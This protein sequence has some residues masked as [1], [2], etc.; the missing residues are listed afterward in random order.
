MRE[1]KN[2]LR[3]RWLCG[4]DHPSHSLLVHSFYCN[5]IRR[6]YYEHTT[7]NEI[8]LS[9]SRWTM[10]FFFHYSAFII[11]LFFFFPIC[12]VVIDVYVCKKP[13]TISGWQ[14]RHSHRLVGWWLHFGNSLMAI[15]VYPC[16]P[17]HQLSLHSPKAHAN[18]AINSVVKVTP[19]L[20]IL[21]DTSDHKTTAI[22]GNNK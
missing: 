14:S 22:Q 10:G 21:C 8:I 16:T 2:I 19:G 13:L 9:S 4:S 17:P 18:A 12:S 3:V 20:P 15:H 1:K 5:Y 11:F 6:T 7:N